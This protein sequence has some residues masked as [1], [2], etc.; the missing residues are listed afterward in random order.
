MNQG[1]RSLPCWAAAETLNS[2]IS[3]NSE[4][5]GE[6]RISSAWA[7]RRDTSSSG[8]SAPRTQVSFSPS[9]C[10]INADS[11]V[12][13]PAGQ[14]RSPDPLQRGRQRWQVAQGHGG[15]VRLHGSCLWFPWKP[16]NPSWYQHIDLCRTGKDGYI[17]IDGG[18]AVH[19][20]SRGRSIMVN[21]K[22]NVYLG[23]SPA[24]H[25]A[26]IFAP[27]ELLSRREFAQISA[28]LTARQAAPRT[29]RP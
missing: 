8:D 15:Q 24:S 16:E 2:S 13:L 20:Q 21:T 17:Q 7:F 23:E 25:P 22:G 1:H 27:F 3:R 5:T 19:G 14:R 6:G 12:Q 26:S 11:N 10:S 28:S 29:R 18:A 4:N 9:S